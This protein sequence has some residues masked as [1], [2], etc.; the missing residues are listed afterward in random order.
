MLKKS[1]RLTT[2]ELEQVIMTGK[3][4]HS[5]LF[6]VR[7]LSG[8]GKKFAAITPKKIIKTAVDRNF[9]R[10]KIY[11][12]LAPVVK[13]IKSDVHI[14]IFSKLTRKEIK[15]TSLETISAELRNIFKKARLAV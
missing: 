6:S 4:V 10:R 15:E 3:V 9:V 2:K 1:Q 13:A 8:S 12:A 11:E 5:T 7:F 14:A